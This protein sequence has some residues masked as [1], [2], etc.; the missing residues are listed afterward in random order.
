MDCLSL[1]GRFILKNGVRHR[2]TALV[3]HSLLVGLAA[4]LFALAFGHTLE[5]ASNLCMR[6]VCGVELPREGKHVQ[7][8]RSHPGTAASALSEGDTGA[9]G[10]AYEYKAPGWPQRLW[11]LFIPALGG[12]LCGLL[13]YSLA[14]EAEGHGT[15][16]VI[17][18]FHQKRGIIRRRIPF[19]KL[20]ASI[21][22]IATGGSAGREGPIAQV[23]AG[24]G[25]ILADVF[26]LSPRRRRILII[27]GVGAGVGSIFR[28]PLG[29][30]LFA[31]EVLYRDTEFEY[32]AL[33]PAFI[34]S[35]VGYTTYAWFTPAGMGPIFSIPPDLHMSHVQL[36]LCILL[37]PIL[38]AAG[39]V[40]VKVFYGATR[41]FRNRV[42]I[43]RHFVPAI[44]GL[45]IGIISL[46]D[47]RLLG[48]GYGWVQETINGHVGIRLILI[49]AAA[50]IFMTAVT[51]GSGGSGG[52]FG[53]SVV[54]GGL[55]GGAFGTICQRWI[56]SV[57]PAAFVLLGMGGFFAGAAKVPISTIIM[58]SEMTVGYAL[59]LPLMLVC[60]LSYLLTPNR[61]GIYI[62]QVGS[63]VD[64][65]AHQ[66]DFVIDVL[67]QMRVTDVM[68]ESQA[69]PLVDESV[70]LPAIFNK[71]SQTRHTTFPVVNAQGDM[72][73]VI[74]L[75]DL[76]SAFME[77][78]LASL[79]IA[80]DIAFQRFEPLATTDN[81]NT[82]LRKMRA[83]RCSELPVVRDEG[84]NEIVGMLSQHE[85]TQ[86]YSGR[87]DELMRDK[88]DGSA[89]A[90][91]GPAL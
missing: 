51:I 63:R 16:S 88:Q 28:A 78:D 7:P 13:V 32:E 20:V 70:L 1:L 53:P 82:A 58:V 44:G 38:V 60:S 86:A 76:R 43:K 77:P 81:L 3:L 5:I 39:I 67:E 61:I 42:R 18:A 87:M 25:S 66:G 6:R 33:I 50:K 26:K 48:T 75:D 52:V 79:I 23:S 21:L 65:P 74:R 17:E 29:G 45:V 69:V 91:S 55:I 59:L 73:G 57:Q 15:D 27:A 89:Q 85:L 46:I 68:A 41:F 71:V 31:V 64:S 4:G 8:G 14:P 83:A 30:A 12:L 62:K 11:V 40:Y 56:P 22:T 35:I 24:V 49:L 10:Y 2:V 34:A 84:S 36:L 80:R 37:V 19:V 47:P 54:I 90:I 72:V 9:G